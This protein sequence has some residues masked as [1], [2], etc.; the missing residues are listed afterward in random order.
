MLYKNIFCTYLFESSGQCHSNEYPQCILFSEI[1]NIILQLLTITH[2]FCFSTI[3][4]TVAQN[5]PYSEQFSTRE[6]GLFEYY[7]NTL[8]ISKTIMI[9][10]IHIVY[11]IIACLGKEAKQEILS[12]PHFPI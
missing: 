2:L 4:L 1:W 10:N 3:F 7:T 8:T 9:V 11:I 6:L 12:N 5:K